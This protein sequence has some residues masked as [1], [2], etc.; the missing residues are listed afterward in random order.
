MSPQSKTSL[1]L[2]SNVAD[3]KHLQLRPAAC[4]DRISQADCNV[5]LIAGDGIEQASHVQTVG[6]VKTSWR[7]MRIHKNIETVQESC[8]LFRKVLS[9]ET[10]RPQIVRMVQAVPVGH[11][12]RKGMV[13]TM[14]HSVGQPIRCNPRN[15]H[16][17]LKD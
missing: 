17:T 7:T 3:S 14:P 1:A 9:A 2:G 8:Q 11:F 16:S 10:Q 6:S 12:H 4:L 5:M 15:G 13:A